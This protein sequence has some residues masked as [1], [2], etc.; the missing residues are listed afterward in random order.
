MSFGMSV[1]DV[2][3]AQTLDMSDF[4]LQK[5]YTTNLPAQVA[6]GQGVNNSHIL[7]DVPGYNPSTCFVTIT[8][9]YY[10]TGASFGFNVI[11]TYKDLG[12]TQIGI[13]TYVNYRQPTGSG[14]GYTDL[15]RANTVECI[16]EVVRFV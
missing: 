2:N 1:W 7:L 12:G 11:P 4:T 14:G 8:P 10:N 5:L 15:W 13:V 3:G 16:I 9:K 6:G